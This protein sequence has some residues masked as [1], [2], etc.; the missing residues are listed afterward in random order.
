MGN[1]PDRSSTDTLYR[2]GEWVVDPKGRTVARQGTSTRLSPRAIEV[3]VYLAQRP[4][5]TITHEE[6]LAEFWRGAISNPN[7]VHKIVNELR[8]ALESAP[9]PTRYI[10]TVPKRG[11]RLVAVVQPIPARGD[12]FALV[13]SSGELPASI[14]ERIDAHAPLA[15]NNGASRTRRYF[16]RRRLIFAMLIGAVLIGIFG[17][18]WFVTTTHEQATAQRSP[19]SPV[20]ERSIAV[21]PFVDMS[22]LKDQQYLAD[23]MTE[24][25][26]NLLANVPGLFVS[27]RTSSFY[28]RST[29][30]AIAEIAR[31]LRVA[32]V[33]EGS[34]RRSG[35]RLRVTAQL[36]RA[37]SGYHE[38]SE[39]YDREVQG[40]LEVQDDIANAVAEALQI[41]LK[42]GT[43]A[44]QSGGTQNL[45]AYE[46][47]LRGNGARAENTESSVNRAIELFERATEID[48]NFG[49]A[50]FALGEA[51]IQKAEMGLLWLG[52]AYVL[53]RPLYERA[54]AVSPNIARAYAGLGYLYFVSDWNWSAADAKVRQ[55][56]EID[57]SDVSVR[58]VAGV[59][60]FA[61]GDWGEA[62]Q[63]LRAALHRDPMN[64]LIRFD[65]GRVYYAAGRLGESEAE[66]REVL[67]T[68]PE[69]I[70]AH[71]YLGRT[72][73]GQGRTEEALATAQQEAEA[74]S[75]FLPILLQAN[76]HAAE[77]RQ[78]LEAYVTEPLPVQRYY[79]AMAYAYL[80]DKDRALELLYQSYEDKDSG[81]LELQ[82]EPLFVGIAN[83]P[84]YAALLAKMNLPRSH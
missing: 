4:G 14:N 67:E 49:M 76:H 5:A 35:D 45:E 62:E 9:E 8:R 73:L 79:S 25:L 10:E 53:A 27:A 70:W 20:P 7:A 42:G 26:I 3:L 80:G 1:T 66:F 21:L 13:P 82:G 83:D 63:H 58:Q 65:L 64:T 2:V 16:D 47:Y 69:F 32:Y 57:P 22:E 41:H 43:L 17:R 46:L 28:F 52:D 77:A 68:S 84:R 56:L 71:T 74:H 60:A 33:I 30:M 54:I 18:L 29:P 19:D 15:Q 37:D 78:V 59:I 23:G 38:W 48:P 24:E 31:E 34:V 55:A 36:I 12:T 75:L 81:L 50:W 39:T 72:L 51:T 40:V 44:H 61:R 11:Y 6:L